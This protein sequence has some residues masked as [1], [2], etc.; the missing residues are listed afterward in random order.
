M[1]D[2]KYATHLV[3]LYYC[4]KNMVQ[5]CLKWKICDTD[6]KAGRIIDVIGNDTV[7]QALCAFFWVTGKLFRWA[8]NF[9][10]NVSTHY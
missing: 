9:L 1:F 8:K 2:L 5:E 10:K 7:Y 6:R 4:G 3:F